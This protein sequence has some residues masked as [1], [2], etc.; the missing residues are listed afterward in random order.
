LEI[1]S[2][3]NGEKHSCHL[4]FDGYSLFWNDGSCPAI[5]LTVTKDLLI[6]ISLILCCLIRRNM[7][8]RHQP[9]DLTVHMDSSPC[10]TGQKAVEQNE[11]ESHDA[12]GSTAEFDL[13]G[14][15]KD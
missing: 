2:A 7:H 8:R 10:H 6:I 5:S 12:R 9:V 11:A 4:K 3:T 15:L 1:E 13:F 14:I